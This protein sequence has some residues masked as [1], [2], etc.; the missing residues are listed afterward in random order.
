MKQ[1]AII[2]GNHP[3]EVAHI[4]EILAARDINIDDLDADTAG[5][6]GTIHI[7][8][9]RYDEA[10]RALREAGYKAMAE[11]ALIIRLEDRPGA[12]AAVAARFRDASLNVR[13]MHIIKH[14]PE[15]V[16]V[17]LVTSDNA[18][19]VELVRDVLVGP[20]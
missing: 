16:L 2:S 7:V 1:I 11:D 10:L 13:S 5:R 8:V 6:R 18:R 9:S 15:Y 14:E 17:S 20:A 12:L 3:G 4:A 19:A